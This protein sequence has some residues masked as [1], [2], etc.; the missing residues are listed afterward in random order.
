M[1]RFGVDYHP[2][3]WPE[4]TRLMSEAGINIVRL[5]EFAWSFL[6]PQPGLSRPLHDPCGGLEG[7]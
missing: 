4:D 6:K 5:A 3:H 7:S 1:F 2:E